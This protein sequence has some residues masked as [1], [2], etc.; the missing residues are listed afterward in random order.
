MIEL[1]IAIALKR[2]FFYSG[3]ILELADSLLSLNLMLFLGLPR[4][5]WKNFYFE[6]LQDIKSNKKGFVKWAK[7]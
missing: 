6:S 1:G 7:N 4:D 5:N 3:M 2:K